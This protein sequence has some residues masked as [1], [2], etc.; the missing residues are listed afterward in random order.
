VNDPANPLTVTGPP[1]R[2]LIG[3]IGLY[4]RHHVTQIRER[5]RIRHRPPGQRQARFAAARQGADGMRTDKT[6]R[7]GHQDHGRAPIPCG[8]SAAWSWIGAVTC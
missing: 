8:G 7:S 2:G 6:Q 3:R 4:H 5:A 1:Q